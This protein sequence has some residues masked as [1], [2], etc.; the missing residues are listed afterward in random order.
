M[1]GHFST[2]QNPQWAVVPMEEEE[3]EEEEEKE[4]EEEE[5]GGGE[6]EEEEEEEE[7]VGQIKDLML[8]TCTVELRMLDLD[9]TITTLTKTLI[10]MV[11][12]MSVFFNVSC[13]ELRTLQTWLQCFKWI[14]DAGS[15]KTGFGKGTGKHGADF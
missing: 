3:E 8:S 4:E 1:E 2:G 6:E 9:V 13:N 5:E 10:I 11:V 15:E 14:C 7:E 12:K